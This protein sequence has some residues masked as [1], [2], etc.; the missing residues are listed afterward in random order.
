MEKLLENIAKIESE[1]IVYAA[2]SLCLAKLY[3]RYD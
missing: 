1:F 2:I 3:F